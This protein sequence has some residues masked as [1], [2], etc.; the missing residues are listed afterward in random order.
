MQNIQRRRII[1]TTL[2][3]LI[4][5][6]TEEVFLVAQDEVEANELVADIL[7]DLLAKADE[8]PTAWH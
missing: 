8:I 1:Q 4:T 6:L 2:G 3:E 5:A 7:S